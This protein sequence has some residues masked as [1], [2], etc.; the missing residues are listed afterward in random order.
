MPVFSTFPEP[1]KTVWQSILFENV[2]LLTDLHMPTSNNMSS[3]GYA[4]PNL[5][6]N[7]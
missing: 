1:L 4:P 2:R 7:S 6:N 3:G 5:F